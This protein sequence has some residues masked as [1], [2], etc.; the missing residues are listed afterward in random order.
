MCISVLYSLAAS[1]YLFLVSFKRIFSNR[2]CRL[3]IH[4]SRLL[5]KISEPDKYRQYANDGT[6]SIGS[7]QSLFRYDKDTHDTFRNTNY[8]PRC[9]HIGTIYHLIFQFNIRTCERIL[10]F[11]RF[12]YSFMILGLSL[13]INK[14]L[15]FSTH[16]FIYSIRARLFLKNG[17][18]FQNN[19]TNGTSVQNLRWQTNY[20]LV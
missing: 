15:F 7:R 18:S 17:N 19:V 9:I 12:Y 14:K 11:H 1:R 6:I 4:S 8:L 2:T 20:S 5:G 13:E 16:S 10:V 3:L